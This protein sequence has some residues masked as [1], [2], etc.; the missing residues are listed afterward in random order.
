MA[1]ETETDNKLKV[2]YCVFTHANG[3]QS[4]I[5]LFTRAEAVA[6]ATRLERTGLS[7]NTDFECDYRI[8][9][10]GDPANVPDW[11]PLVQK[12]AQSG[13]LYP[14][15][16]KLIAALTEYHPDI[17]LVDSY[18]VGLVSYL[19]DKNTRPGAVWGVMRNSPQAIGARGK[20]VLPYGLFDRLYKIEPGNF[21]LMTWNDGITRERTQSIAEREA[22][23]RDI[24][25]KEPSPQTQA[26]FADWPEW[27][28]RHRRNSY[29]LIAPIVLLIPAQVVDRRAARLALLRHA[30]DSGQMT[31]TEGEMKA[32]G[33][34][35]KPLVLVSLTAG[36][37]ASGEY[38][39]I[40]KWL[41]EKMTEW[42][43][44][45]ISETGRLLVQVGLSFPKL[46]EIWRYLAG[47]DYLLTSAGYNTFHEVRLLAALG[48]FE[49]KAAFRAMEHYPD[50]VWRAKEQVG[51]FDPA[52]FP[53][54]NAEFGL[55]LVDNGADYLAVAI[56]S[57]L[58]SLSLSLSRNRAREGEGEAH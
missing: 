46:S 26:D 44:D 58:N 53:P 52:R 9:G 47:V 25:Y 27:Y 8:Y 41:K 10:T 29:K 56:S 17:L 20:Y 54:P 43:L 6:R 21:G 11:L 15:A 28:K 35:D 31:M 32:C 24:S 38:L 4:G 48:L 22:G 55:G 13:Y 36:A 12:D 16:D 1:K 33:N 49:G 3:P 34:S 30:V 23:I 18:P 39:R 2:A 50:Q 19:M 45:Q 7:D 37:L 51:L 57:K 42:G 14:D 40:R 5:G